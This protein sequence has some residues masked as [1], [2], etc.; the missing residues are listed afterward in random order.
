MGA[1]TYV[2]VLGVAL[3]LAFVK[4]HIFKCYTWSYHNPWCTF[5]ILLEDQ[6]NLFTKLVIKILYASHLDGKSVV[7]N[8]LEYSQTHTQT[9]IHM[10]LLILFALCSGH[11]QI[12]RNE[13]C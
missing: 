11:A 8:R 4:A 5:L 6:A 9:H 7:G 10:N 3:W 12:F 13:I 2:R 1:Y